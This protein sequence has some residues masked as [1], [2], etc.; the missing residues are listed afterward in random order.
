[1]SNPRAE[2]TA[3]TGSPSPVQVAYRVALAVF[4]L[5]GIVQIFLAGLGAFSARGDPG[6]GP[7]R[8]VGFAM[9]GVALV[10]VV[11]ALLA[12]AGG[13]AIGV[14]AVLL[15]LVAVV[16]SLL[17]SVGEDSAFV[18]GLHALDGLV[19]LGLAGYLQGTARRVA[20]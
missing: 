15:L 3:T 11:L 18:G 17:A 12:R 16:Q 7:H 14:A 8:A 20:A 9:A 2:P 10:I 6:F 5:M 19:I 4:L 1:M 13:R